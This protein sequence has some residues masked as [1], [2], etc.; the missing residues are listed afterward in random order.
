MNSSHDD[1]TDRRRR[2]AGLDP[3]QLHFPFYVDLTRPPLP[4]DHDDNADEREGR[5]KQR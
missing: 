3:R 1:D 2:Y 5:M 4:E